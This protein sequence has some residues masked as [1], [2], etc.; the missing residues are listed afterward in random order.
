MKNANPA[1]PD[2]A[3]ERLSRL[4]PASG[5]MS[6]PQ[7]AGAPAASSL[8][9]TGDG[10]AVHA[11]LG[12]AAT[13]TSDGVNALPAR[14]PA[15]AQRA[16]IRVDRVVG[17]LRRGRP[18]R[19][20]AGAEEILVAAVETMLPSAWAELRGDGGELSVT[21]TAERA[22]ASGWHKPAAVQALSDPAAVALSVPTPAGVEAHA[23]APLLPITLRLPEN[24]EPSR[25]AELAG[26]GSH[27]AEAGGEI[28]ERPADGGDRGNG[29]NGRQD[30]QRWASLLALQSLAP[31]AQTTPA[32]RAALE[33]A[34]LARL[35]PAVVALRLAESGRLHPGALHPG[36][37]H[38]EAELDGDPDY[39]RVS[40][41]DVLAYPQ[42]RAGSLLRVSE[43]PVP[44]AGHEETR[45]VLFRETVADLEHVAIILGQPDPAE[46]VLVRLHSSCL[47]GDLFASLRCDCGDQLRGA[48]HRLGDGGGILL[49]L[50]QEG[51][52]IGLANKLRA[53]AR[54][55][56][57]LDTI[58]ADRYLGFRGDERNF[59][60][61]VQILK[62][63]GIGRIRLL[64]NNPAKIAALRQAGLD[65]VERLPIGG[66]INRHNER[67]ITTKRDRAGHLIDVSTL[68]V[69]R[70]AG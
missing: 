29:A 38:G 70:Q 5:A 2:A 21:L 62:S 53:Y 17:E 54:Q 36:A 68:P 67:Y 26:L 1:A 14:T 27:A 56:T 45:F 69:A 13:A 50:A 39:L 48:I 15:A 16:G 61:A 49:Y 63:L 55:D 9:G 30:G 65:V 59:A 41:A 20:I 46:P 33:L 28:V 66:E 43:A 22:Q 44:L 7:V 11:G 35:V 64:T 10:D 31:S 12:P 47:T 51:R 4:A 34:R 32:M 37:L 57:G 52:G 18:V 3:P 6:R 19:L 58:D 42:D 60:V 25:L 40:A 24:F 8:N 23:P